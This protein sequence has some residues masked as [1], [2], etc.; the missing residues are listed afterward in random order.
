M[1]SHARRFLTALALFLGLAVV[2]PPALAAGTGTAEAGKPAGSASARSAVA[3]MQ[4]GWNLGN[5]LDST[6]ADETSWGNPRVTRE[7][8]RSVRA[9]GFKSIRIPVTWSRHQGAA[10]SY[11]VDPAYL[12][13]VKEVVDW[14]LDEDLY[15]LINVHHDSWQWVMN[16]PTQHDAVLARYTATWTQIAE[17]FRDAPGKLLFE[18][19]NE[20]YFDGSSGDAQNA[21]LMHELNSTFHTLVRASGGRNATR[22]LVLPTLRSS[23]DQARVDELV[24][25]FT[26]LDDP[27]LVATIH[28]YGFWPFSVNI[29]GYTR[30]DATTQKDL[31][32]TL[33]RLYNTFVAHGIPVIIGEYGLLGFDRSTGTIEQ[34][35]KLKFFEYLGNY[36]RLRQL[37]TMLWDNGQH[38]HRSELRWNDPG[39]YRQLRSSWTVS[40]ATAATDQV[41]VRKGQAPSDA[42]VAL[43]LNGNRLTSIVHGS[44]A[45]VRGRDYSVDGDQLT[46]PAATL[47]RLTAS[48]EYG[49]NAVLSLRFS[50]GVPW[51][52]NVITYEAPTLTGATGTTGSLVIPTAF[53]G[54]QLATMEAVYADGTNAGPQDW[55]SYKEFGYTFAPDYTAG[56]ITLQ[57]VFFDAVRDGSTVTLTFHFWSGTTVKYRL[58]RSGTAVT[59]EPIA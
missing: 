40:S 6:G 43:N 4:P 53:R 1:K 22:L 44:K 51:D 47:A 38:F 2:P 33:D 54:D 8:L 59:G 15:V 10:P 50:R 35:E 31:T 14:A 32:E 45:L 42:R 58:T 29:A 11:T 30:F 3:A 56:K 21:E 48:Q 12:A 20:P 49:V 39:L 36:A 41:F 13:R 25:T 16:L 23:P 9:Q 19:V 28:Y 5:T 17:T 26:A 57:S 34:G 37:T 18:S 55:T 52:L 24:D 27:N 7:L 46:L